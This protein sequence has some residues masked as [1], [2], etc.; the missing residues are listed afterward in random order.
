MHVLFAFLGSLNLV[1]SSLSLRTKL[2]ELEVALLRFYVTGFRGDW[3]AMRAMFSFQ[4]HYN[5][6]EATVLLLDVFS[7]N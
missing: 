2:A 5:T 6:N 3:K 4:R 7:K 1:I